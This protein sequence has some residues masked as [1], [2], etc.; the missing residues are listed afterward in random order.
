MVCVMKN[1]NTIAIFDDD[2]RLKNNL[3]LTNLNSDNVYRKLAE[4]LI[5]LGYEVNTLD[6]YE[7]NKEKPQICIFLDIPINK[8]S[9]YVDTTSTTPV[10]LLREADIVLKRNY[11]K[12]RHKEFK[13]I[14]T[15]KSDLLDGIKYF[16]FPS[17]KVQIIEKLNKKYGEKIKPF[18]L[19]NSNL[20]SNERGELYT[21]R[22]EIAKWFQDN[23]PTEFDLWGPNWDKRII[24]LPANLK[25]KIP[26][27]NLKDV[28]RGLAKDKYQTLRDYKFC[29][30][31]ENTNKIKDYISEK[32][33]D[34][35]LAGC[36][37]VYYGDPGIADKI[38]TD[39]FIDYRD[40]SS[41]EDLYDQL[42]YM[43]ESHYNQYLINIK[44]Y[45]YSKDVN[46]FTNVTWED[47][48][49]N[50]ISKISTH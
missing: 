47:S 44:K 21:K 11:C 10:V 26:C 23:H 49:I 7:K 18:V 2:Y 17:T 14:L 36:V 1:K 30:C 32:I 39:C 16:H 8:V 15:W 20:H 25:I 34:C 46:R 27:N 19:I 45:L 35:F 3:F 24:K 42:N 33:F 38:P 37:P 13:Y 41:I 43:L 50:L 22:A 12:E 6:V 40:F 31:F 28:Y 4:K 29:I 9:T 48:I 5:K